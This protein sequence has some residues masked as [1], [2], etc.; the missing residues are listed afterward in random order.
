[1]NSRSYKHQRL[2][3]REAGLTQD[4]RTVTSALGGER[5]EADYSRSDLQH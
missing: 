5:D 4:D 2:D 1:M 3:E